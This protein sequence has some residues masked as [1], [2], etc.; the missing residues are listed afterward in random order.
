MGTPANGI[1]ALFSLKP[2]FEGL[3]DMTPLGT[4]PIDEDTPRY[5]T[6]MYIPAGI[7]MDDVYKA[8]ESYRVYCHQ[9]LAVCNYGG[10]TV[11]ELYDAAG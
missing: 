3:G 4:Y 1:Y 6:I 10:V 5:L 9:W 8:F 11:G 2:I 7:Y